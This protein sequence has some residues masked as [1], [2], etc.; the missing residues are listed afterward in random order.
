MVGVA[1]DG[2]W[3]DPRDETRRGAWGGRGASVEAEGSR[4][5]RV[6]FRARATGGSVFGRRML[7]GGG[8]ER[9]GLWMESRQRF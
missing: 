1:G 4:S 8:D 2:R 6:D 3:S 5:R 9:R 7:R